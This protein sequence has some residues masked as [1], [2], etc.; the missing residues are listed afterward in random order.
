MGKRAADT[1]VD[2]TNGGDSKDAG[3]DL[4]YHPNM[5]EDQQERR[6]FMLRMFDM[7]NRQ[8]AAPE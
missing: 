1:D 8:N 3:D 7:V 5:S 2:L 6:N 4:S